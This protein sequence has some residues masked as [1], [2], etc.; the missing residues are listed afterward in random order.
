MDT[1]GIMQISI[2]RTQ[3]GYRLDV[4]TE[5]H[6]LS[7]ILSVSDAHSLIRMMRSFSSAPP[8]TAGYTTRVNYHGLSLRT[9][10]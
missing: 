10:S 1:S 2:R 9:N 7:C 6:D 5:A 3:S 4:R 8:E